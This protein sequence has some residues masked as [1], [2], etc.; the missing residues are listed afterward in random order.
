MRQSGF[1]RNRSCRPV[2]LPSRGVA[3]R[4]AT[5]VEGVPTEGSPIGSSQYKVS[6]TEE[7][8]PVEWLATEG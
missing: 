3:Y 8:T 5:L 6:P 4:E 7:V 2:S 1:R